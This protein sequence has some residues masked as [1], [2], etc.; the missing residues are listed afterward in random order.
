MIISVEAEVYVRVCCDVCKEESVV[1]PAIIHTD[2]MDALATNITYA[3]A[4]HGLRVQ[5]D[6]SWKCWGCI[7]DENSE[8]GT[9]EETPSV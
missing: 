9:T 5:E 8:R 6:G 4:S 1:G 3:L 2:R 7:S